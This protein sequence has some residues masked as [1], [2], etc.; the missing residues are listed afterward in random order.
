MKP[1]DKILIA[2]NEFAKVLPAISQKHAALASRIP[3]W[4]GAYHRL[5]FQSVFTSLPE[6]KTVLI[7]GVYL[8][9]DIATMLEVAPTGLQVVGVDKFADTPCDDWPES[10]RT[11]S[12]EQA[13]FG[14]APNA[15]QALTNINPQPPHAVRLIEADDAAWLPTIKGKFDLC[16]LDTSHDK[17]TCLRQMAQVRPL[18]HETTVVAGDDYENLEPTWGVRDAVAEA[19]TTHRVLAKTIWF[20]DAADYK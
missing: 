15:E 18:C 14:K 10:K 4:S 6:V 7:L 19:F 16:Y 13:G 1:T 20:A 17:A 11:L 3:G 12:W 8:G 9:R 5:F 2:I